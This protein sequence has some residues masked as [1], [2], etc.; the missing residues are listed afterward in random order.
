MNLRF[1]IKEKMDFY[2]LYAVKAF[3]KLLEGK[4]LFP[5]LSKEEDINFL[6]VFIKTTFFFLSSA[7]HRR[8]PP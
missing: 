7:Q 4:T 1:I 8:D 2:L 6:K 5:F 3:Y